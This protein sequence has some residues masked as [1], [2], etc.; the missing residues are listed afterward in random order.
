MEATGWSL[1]AAADLDVTPPPITD[2]LRALR[3]LTAGERC[4]T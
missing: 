3:V 4:Y 1:A 2:E